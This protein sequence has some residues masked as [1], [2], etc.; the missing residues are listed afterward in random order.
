[1]HMMY[2]YVNMNS[3]HWVITSTTSDCWSDCNWCG[4]TM[5][6]A[7]FSGDF[8][9]QSRKSSVTSVALWRLA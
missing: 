6:L 9:V 4:C 3:I 2:M 8:V 5:L 7:D 1:M